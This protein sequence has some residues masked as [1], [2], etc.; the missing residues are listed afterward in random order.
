[1]KDCA[2]TVRALRLICGTSGCLQA[3]D[4][5]GK[6]S[7]VY[8]VLF[9]ERKT[10]FSL[11]PFRPG[12]DLFIRFFPRIQWFLGGRRRLGQRGIADGFVGWTRSFV[13]RKRSA[14]TARRGDPALLAPLARSN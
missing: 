1:M 2:K 3:V 7:P 6:P 14:Q 8:V 9:P 5:F 4:L 12:P 11:P 13:R 10:D